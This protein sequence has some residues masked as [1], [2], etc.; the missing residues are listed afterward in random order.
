[1]KLTCFWINTNKTFTV[2]FVS[3]N[4]QFKYWTAAEKI[5]LSL[6]FHDFWLWK[7][8]STCMN[9]RHHSVKTEILGISHLSHSRK[10][11]VYWKE[12]KH[13]WILRATA[14]RDTSNWGLS[15]CPSSI[16]LILITVSYTAL[17][18]SN[19]DP[20]LHTTSGLQDGHNSFMSSKWKFL[21]NNNLGQHESYMPFPKSTP[22]A[23]RLT[24]W[25]SHLRIIACPLSTDM[26]R[27]K[28]ADNT[29]MP[30]I[31]PYKQKTFS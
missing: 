11:T 31:G 25:L 17:Y 2:S 13:I 7:Y 21:K 4:K 22:K 20:G 3:K 10:E 9:Q 29:T 6:F 30:S 15:F 12:H 23:V 14:M 5:K 24:P 19:W 18:I 26:V 16:L 27:K 8:C 1:M 28:V